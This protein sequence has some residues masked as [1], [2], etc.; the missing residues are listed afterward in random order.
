MGPFPVLRSESMDY[1]AQL[2]NFVVSNFLFGEAGKLQDD[3][4]L[5]EEGIIDSTGILE[6][7]TFMETAFNVRVE[8]GELLPENLGSIRRAAQFIER[9]LNA[10]VGAPVAV[11]L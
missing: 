2:R 1:I 6:L 3:T 5:L 9:K 11:Q 4:P 7:I 10:A 8:N